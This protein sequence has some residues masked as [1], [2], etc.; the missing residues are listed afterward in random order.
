MS[1][2]LALT[3]SLHA[4]GTQWLKNIVSWLS[5][6][7][8][9]EDRQLA[10]RPAPYR[11]TV[12]ESTAYRIVSSHRLQFRSPLYNHV[13]SNTELKDDEAITISKSV[14]ALLEAELQWRLDTARGSH[15]V[16]L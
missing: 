5:K 8:L 11:P 14:Y 2:D 6:H 9:P 4:H 12:E 13:L 10:S 3:A 1:F 7:V 15:A 16:L